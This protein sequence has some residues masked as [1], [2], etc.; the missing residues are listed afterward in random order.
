VVRLRLASV[1]ALALV[2]AGCS[3]GPTTSG[4]PPPIPS[5]TAPGATPSAAPGFPTADDGPVLDAAKA[6]V[7]KV[8][9]YDHTKLGD[10]LK[11]VLPLAGEP[12][13]GQLSKS[14]SGD[15]EFA[16]TVRDN[17][18]NA[19]G[20]VTDVGLVSREGDRAVVL[21]F[22]DQQ[23]TSPAIDTTEH[24]RERVTLNQAKTGPSSGSWLAT[25]LET[26]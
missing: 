14:L 6:F 8:S 23:I 4:P 15:G 10:Q 3:T 5:S 1:P 12:L 19:K 13:K 20:T 16:T 22:V 7:E 11:V 21:V 25:K 17:S 26:I 18:R 9:T 2:A 24:R